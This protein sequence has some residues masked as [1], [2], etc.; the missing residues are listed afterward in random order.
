MLLETPLTHPSC[1]MSCVRRGHRVLAL[2]SSQGQCGEQP[3]ILLRTAGGSCENFR[4]LPY[5]HLYQGPRSPAEL[6]RTA[7]GYKKLCS[8]SDIFMLLT[9]GYLFTECFH[10][11]TKSAARCLYSFKQLKCINNFGQIISRHDFVELIF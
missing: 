4:V 3:A 8:S 7:Y 1:P 6:A 11:V 5:S 2:A 9:N 10:K